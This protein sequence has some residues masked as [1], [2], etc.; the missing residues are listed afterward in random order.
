M[1][2]KNKRA[3]I[4]GGARG[5][6]ATTAFVFAEEGAKV[7]IVDFRE[8]GLRDI[9]AQAKQKGFEFRTFVGDVSKKDQVQ[10]M[11]KEFVQEFGGIDILVNNAGIAIS[12]P[13]LEKT[14]EDWEK[15]LGVNLIGVFLCSQA[16][17]Q[18]MLKQNSGKIINISS[19]RGIEHCGREGIMDYSASKAAVINLTKTMAKELAPTITVNTVA[20][21]HTLTEMTAALPEEVKRNMIEGSY[22][23]RMAE[24]ID[25]AKAI[26]F[27]ASE[28]ADFITSQVLLVDGGFS[29]K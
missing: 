29:L 24:P 9:A 5:I 26:L 19:I 3:L 13:F 4:T 7:G 1:R 20:P 27:L 23:K 11:M 22:L 8:E 25:I 16:A 21:G 6:G 15:T 12:R 17:A 28:D 2:V 10:R 14:V 18:H